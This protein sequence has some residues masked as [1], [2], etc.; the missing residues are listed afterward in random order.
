MADH[1]TRLLC[2]ALRHKPELFGITIDHDGW[3]DLRSLV[4]GIRAHF[5]TLENVSLSHLQERLASQQEERFELQDNRLRA[6]YGHSLTHV[7]VGTAASPPALLFHSTRSLL[8]PRIRAEGL[9][10]K[11][12]T[13]VHLTSRW[14]YAQSLRDS[15]TKRGQRGIILA[16]KGEETAFKGLLFLQANS[17]VWL[18]PYI[19]S[20]FLSVVPNNTALLLPRTFV[21]IDSI[22]SRAI[23]QSTFTV[24]SD[25]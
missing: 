14:S 12:R 24:F 11:G 13:G 4:N 25:D 23:L 8:L 9:I 1:L 19:P 20:R 6:L 21:P 17:H 5:P 10:S 2:L 16:I 22:E 18:S 7:S 3:A 15:H